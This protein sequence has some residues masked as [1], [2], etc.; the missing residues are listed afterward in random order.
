[1]SIVTQEK[2]SEQCP[3]TSP[4]RGAGK[5]SVKEK[6]KTRLRVLLVEDDA[7][8]A[9]LVLRALQNDGFETTHDVADTREAFTLKIRTAPYDIVLADYNLPQW[10][11]RSRSKFCAKRAWTSP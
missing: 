5:E 4:S 6:P 2:S 8:D 3:A 10:E 11:G 7:A 9:E 1:M